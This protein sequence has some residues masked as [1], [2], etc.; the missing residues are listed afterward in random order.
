MKLLQEL[1]LLI[2]AKE[3]PVKAAPVIAKDEVAVDVSPAPERLSFVYRPKYDAFPQLEQTDDVELA[4]EVKRVYAALGQ[5]KERGLVFSIS[6]GAERDF[7]R[8]VRLLSISTDG[9]VN[10]DRLKRAGFTQA[11]RVGDKRLMKRG[12]FIVSIIGNTDEVG[13]VTFYTSKPMTD[14]KDE[15]VS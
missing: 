12:D 9:E 2:E 4:R 3:A 13:T 6:S 10:M 11:G 8:L 5:E 1:S 14:K 15:V 7:K